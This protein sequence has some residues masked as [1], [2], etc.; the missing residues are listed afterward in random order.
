MHDRIEEIEDKLA[1]DLLIVRKLQYAYDIR[2]YNVCARIINSDNVLL[3]RFTKV[4]ISAKYKGRQI[5][6]KIDW[7]VKAIEPCL[8]YTSPSPRDRS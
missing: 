4:A 6:D 2:D 1:S 3:E 7:I 8:L 5:T